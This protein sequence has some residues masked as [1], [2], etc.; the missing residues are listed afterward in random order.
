MDDES[1][2]ENESGIR[3]DLCII[4]Q[5][6]GDLSCCYT[7]LQKLIDYSIAIGNNTLTTFCTAKLE[8]NASVNIH[9]NCQKI[10]G[11]TLLSIKRKAMRTTDRS[12][13][14]IRKTTRAQTNVFDWKKQCMYCGKYCNDQT[15]KDVSRVMTMECKDS[16]LSVCAERNDALSEEV[17]N[18]VINCIDLV[19]AEA[20][21]HRGCRSKFWLGSINASVVPGRSR[22]RPEDE[23]KMDCFE[24]MCNWMESEAELYTV[25]ELREKLKE[26]AQDDNVYQIKWIKEK[27]KIKYGDH[28]SFSSLRGHSDIV[29]L[30]DITNYIITDQ[31]YN[32]KKECKDDEVTR[33]V[34]TAAKIILDEIRSKQYNTE[35]YPTVE[36]IH[37][38][39]K[40]QQL[41]PHNLNIFLQTLLKSKL[42]Q[43]SIGQAIVL[44]AHP[45]SS[46]LP[47]P[48]GLGIE[49]DSVFGSRWLV[50]EL[51]K[52]GFSVSYDEV[53]RFKQS[54]LQ[55][56]DINNHSKVSSNSFVQWVRD[57]VDHNLATLDGKKTFHGMG[58]IAAATPVM[59]DQDTLN[60][61]YS[62]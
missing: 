38:V 27:L 2:L 22:G 48:F 10:V 29:C 23:D 31:W 34:T 39:E 32:K 15:D 6:G 3:A 60:I 44:A 62:N 56:D 19:Q 25:A 40:G 59:A 7:G 37:D 46:L 9:R 11:N 58:I 35:H 54:V 13:T 30:K 4:C 49:M 14:K 36:D 51:F 41:L 47:V 61:C 55:H 52:L 20:R 12:D 24:K 53:S 26:I 33:I 16:I 21:Y 28:I 18:R 5:C 8:D 42:K 1:E 50:D 45:R 57:N 43:V 17:R